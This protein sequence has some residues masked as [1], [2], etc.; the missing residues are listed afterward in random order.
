MEL[1][2][3]ALRVRGDEPFQLVEAAGGPVRE[4]G[5]DR[6]LQRPVAAEDRLR[7]LPLPLVQELGRVREVARLPVLPDPEREPERRDARPRLA[8]RARR[9]RA[10]APGL[11]ERDAHRSGH[12]R[13]CS[14]RDDR[15]HTRPGAHRA[16]A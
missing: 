16:S 1:R 7:R 11:E 14:H 15:E 13:G 8:D 6:R 2:D 12:R 3:R 9:A 5:S 10:L 4:G